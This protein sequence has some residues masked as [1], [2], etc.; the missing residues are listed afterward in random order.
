MEKW[1]WGCK[2]DKLTL[3]KFIQTVIGFINSSFH[4]ARYHSVPVGNG[5]ENSLKCQPC[6]TAGH[7]SKCGY[8]KGDVAFFRQPLELKSIND[9]L[10]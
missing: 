5:L 7:N 6:P 4:I 10:V 2:Y 3:Y 9:P 1:L 8:F